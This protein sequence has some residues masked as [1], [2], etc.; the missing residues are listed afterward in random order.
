[1]IDLREHSYR[2]QYYNT[3]NAYKHNTVHVTCILPCMCTQNSTLLFEVQ[4]LCET[5]KKS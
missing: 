4:M 2:F 3:I 5:Q 1:M